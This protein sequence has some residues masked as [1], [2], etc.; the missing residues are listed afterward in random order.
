MSID[1]EI[2]EEGKRERTRGMNLVMACNVFEEELAKANLLDNPEIQKLLQTHKREA[3]LLLLGDAEAPLPH[4][5]EQ[6]IDDYI[7]VNTHGKVEGFHD[8]Y[9]DL[10][11]GKKD[12]D[13][14][15]EAFLIPRARELE[16]LAE[17]VIVQ[18]E[19][20]QPMVAQTLIDVLFTKL[21]KE[22][23][24][25]KRLYGLLLINFQHLP[26][27]SNLFK[28]RHDSLMEEWADLTAAAYFQKHGYY[29]PGYLKTAKQ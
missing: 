11:K 8:R 17:N 27:V 13:P 15:I 22:G 18:L 2:R 9:A 10:M 12:P 4:T 7:F 5:P 6:E 23:H 20:E 3:A 19:K 28:K 16:D 26:Y 21:T 29:P 1:Y 25:F 14:N 24:F